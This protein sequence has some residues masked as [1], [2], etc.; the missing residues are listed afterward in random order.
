MAQVFKREEAAMHKAEH[1]DFARPDE[2]REFP[3][4]RVELARAR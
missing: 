1:K 3:K 2:V 4:G